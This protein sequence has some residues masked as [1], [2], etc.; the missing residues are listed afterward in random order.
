MREMV[1]C[2]N[3]RRPAGHVRSRQAESSLGG[4]TG[5][6]RPTLEPRVLE[7]DLRR[8]DLRTHYRA[9]DGASEALLV[10]AHEAR[11]PTSGRLIYV[12]ATE[13]VARIVMTS[14]ADLEVASSS[15]RFLGLRS[16]TAASAGAGA[17][18]AG[19][20][21]LPLVLGAQPAR[22]WVSTTTP[23]PAALARRPRLS[24]RASSLF[25]LPSRVWKIVGVVTGS[26]P[27]AP[28]RPGGTRPELA[29]ALFVQPR[30]SISPAKAVLLLPGARRAGH[31]ELRLALD[32]SAN[33]PSRFGRAQQLSA[34]CATRPRRPS[35]AASRPS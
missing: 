26:F 2:S 6:A 25:S 29:V 27:I 5:T 30:P 12:M 24:A 9:V 1:A 22:S 3:R 4:S 31:D 19:S 8:P 17:R 35:D 16:E 11:A 34:R 7:P 21:E 28:G 15:D 13:D 18:G 33:S 20:P 14:S 32:L 10:R 23:S